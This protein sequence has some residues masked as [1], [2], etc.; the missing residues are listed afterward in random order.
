MQRKARLFVPISILLMA[1]CSLKPD[2]CD[3]CSEWADLVDACLET[4]ESDYAVSPDCQDEFDPDWFDEKGK[5]DLSDQALYDSYTSSVRACESGDDA[6]DSCKKSLAAAREA[7]EEGG[8]GASRQDACSEEANV[9]P[10]IDAAIANLDCEGF[11]T[12]VGIL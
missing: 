10:E 9:N 6:Y 12:A 8:F 3:N 1:G 5:L 11:L 7:A 2:A 4:W